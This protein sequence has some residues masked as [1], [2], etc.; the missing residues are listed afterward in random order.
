MVPAPSC[1]YTWDYWTASPSYYVELTCLLPNSVY[2]PLRPTWNA[3]LRHVKE[4]STLEVPRSFRRVTHARCFRQFCAHKSVKQV[5][6][7]SNM[8]R[9]SCDFQKV[10]H[11][12]YQSVH[13]IR[14]CGLSN[15]SF[16]KQL[17][18]RYK[19]FNLDWLRQKLTLY[20]TTCCAEICTNIL[21]I[22]QLNDIIKIC[23]V[24]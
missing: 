20:L 4:V 11:I 8:C 1:P 19:V 18:C 24:F 13:S 16:C 3:T 7:L 14:A 22:K 9:D 17:V 15:C 5:K 23:Y 6:L 12:V 2:I 21:E 10:D